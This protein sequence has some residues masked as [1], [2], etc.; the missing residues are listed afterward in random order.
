MGEARPQGRRPREATRTAAILPR[1]IRAQFD[2]EFRCHRCGQVAELPLLSR[3]TGRGTAPTFEIA[4]GRAAPSTRGDVPR[5]AKSASKP[6]PWAGWW[7][8]FARKSNTPPIGAS[9]AKVTMRQ[10]ASPW[11]AGQ[12]RGITEPF[13]SHDAERQFDDRG[14]GGT[15]MMASLWRWN[16]S[17]AAIWIEPSRFTGR[18][19]TRSRNT[20]RPITVLECCTCNR[21]EQPR[22]LKYLFAALEASPQFPDYWLGYL[23]ALLAAGQAA[24]AATALAIATRTRP[25]RRGGRGFRAAT[26]G[27]VH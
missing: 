12:T 10:C 6:S 13:P 7:I 9:S 2:S 14:C 26:R 8:A 25:D 16:F 22:G 4:R 24:D 15:P 19:S 18:F 1:R 23:E 11:R 3:S 20:P 17:S 5:G 27:Q 21:I